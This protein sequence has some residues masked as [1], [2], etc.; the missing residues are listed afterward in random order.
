MAELLSMAMAV[1]IDDDA[2]DDSASPLDLNS[3]GSNESA[4]VVS[5]ED[6]A[7]ADS[8]LV[9]DLAISDRGMDSLKHALLDTFPS[10]TIFSSV[11]RDDSPQESRVFPTIEEIGIS[12]IVDNTIYDV[13]P[14]NE[15]DANTTHHLINNKDT[16]NFM[17]RINSENEFLPISNEDLRLVEASDSEVDSQFAKLVEEELNDDIFKVWELDIQDE[18]D[19]LVKQLYE[20]LGGSSLDFSPSA[21]ENLL[22]M[23]DKLLDDIISGLDGLSLSP[24]TD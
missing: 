2:K 4:D 21:S 12:G 11:M 22:V 10:K 7:W 14:T 5:S 1:A 24:T 13:S 16:D 17:S 18:E 15:Q 23:D 9:S 6:V 20:A 8:C 3:I 19:E